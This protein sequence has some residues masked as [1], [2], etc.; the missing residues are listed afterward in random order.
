MDTMK[1]ARRLVLTLPASAICWLL[2]AGTALA[3]APNNSTQPTISPT[4]AQVGTLLTE[5][6]GTWDTSL[7]GFTYQWFDC[8][9][10]G[11]TSGCNV[12]SG[13]INQ[14]Y[15]VAPSDGGFTIAVQ[16]TA[17]DTSTPV[18]S[19][20][21]TAEVLPPPSNTSLPTISGTAQQG[22][23]LTL[24]QGTWSNSPSITDMWEDCGASGASCNAIGGATGSTYT[25]TAN[26]V[27]HTIEV[28][29]TASNA[30]NT[31]TASSAPTATVTRLPAPVNVTVP[32]IS[33]T[34]VPGNTLTEVHGTWTNGPTSYTYQ[35]E[36]CSGSPLT[37]TAL[38]GATAATYV[39]ATGDAGYAFEVQETAV[40]AGGASAP[41]TSSVVLPP[42]P[43]NSTLPTISGTNVPGNTLTEVHGTWTNGPTSYT[44]QWE[45]CSGSPLTCTAIS[46]ATAQTYVLTSADAG[47]T[48][49]V[50]ETASNAGGASA[51]ASS[52]G[53]ALTAPPSN[54]SAPTI[55]GIA[56]QGQTLTESHGHWTNAPTSY[57]VEWIRCDGTGNTCVAVA[58]QISSTY[59]L[60]A[61][62]VGGTIELVET[63]TNA[64]GSN[65][66]YSA[67]TSV[68]TTP[69]GIVPPP[70]DVS[71]PSVSGTAQ[72]GGTLMASQGSWNNN[73][74][75]YTYQWMRC[76][77]SSCAAIPGANAGS[78][79]PSAADVG[80]AI[81][82]METATN[83]GGNSI[84]VISAR[85]SVVTTTSATTLVAP[86][87]P[88]TNQTV[89]VVAT[90]T[91]S[92]GNASPSGSITFKNGA[93]AIGGC[94]NQPVS[95]TA[96]SATVTCQTSFAAGT[97]PLSATYAP[98][99]G[100]IVMGSSSSNA[101][102]T[103]EPA[104]TSTSL[105][106]SGLV[107]V[108]AFTT[109][110]ATVGQP[111]TGGGPVHPSGTITF[112]DNNKPIAA[113]LLRPLV[114]TGATCR[115]KYKSAGK[116][117]IVA[118]YSG[119]PN[120]RGSRSSVQRVKVAPV[121]LGYLTSS[122]GWTV[123]FTATHTWFTQFMVFSVP[124]GTSFFFTC[125]GR[126]CPFV[127]HTTTVGKGPRC[128][129]KRKHRCPSSRTINLLSVFHG[130]QVGVGSKITMS[131]LRCGWYGRY[132]TLAI[133]P[134]R[135]PR[136]VIAT[137]PVGVTRPG[138]RC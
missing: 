75:A 108:G 19:A 28:L 115:L 50:Q 76:Q 122:I 34:N 129:S 64:G 81:E 130:A 42:V 135:Q 90:V 91:S 136:Q 43:T 104:P 88:V 17:Y 109:Y 30:S 95:S 133:R 110:Q 79:A 85:T 111:E 69:A 84:P 102:V 23:V 78:Y 83:T 55:S 37:C 67:L 35:W 87:V 70:T 7:S 12:I 124:P 9:A 24:T 58:G 86:S 113:C 11:G 126:S 31:A 66:A 32:S 125:H 112:L 116:H 39:V 62:D 15:S 65:S 6:N 73:P 26:D 74:N 52:A 51:A 72:Q 117:S 45:R 49:E 10:S 114:N 92:S 106:A 53:S 131:I 121:A 89:T 61:A 44:Y 97:A 96:Q 60:T 99:S 2:L 119:D 68:V 40:N 8:P 38:S 71:S 98:G 93:G 118:R 127:T 128:T 59:N 132:Y 5:T 46:G 107:N 120:F 82:V 1:I 57:A 4:A 105:H 48:I 134:Q 100:S 16:E 101:T 103:V 77:G 137:L 25:L 41:A 13:A 33:G 56:Q 18:W 3:A 20:N 36:R 80:F 14:T 27:G 123:K 94:S 47:S 21:A 138:L 22:Q 29:E 63:A 54:T